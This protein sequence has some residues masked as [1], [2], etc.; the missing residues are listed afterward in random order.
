MLVDEGIGF[1]M[2]RDESFGK[3]VAKAMGWE[4][5]REKRVRWTLLFWTHVLARRGRWWS[6]RHRGTADR[7]GQTTL[8][9][10]LPA[11][12]AY[13]TTTDPVQQEY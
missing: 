6:R 1:G 2:R 5:S 11:E 10:P 12:A 9:W 7:G 3:V 13:F 4:V 8:K